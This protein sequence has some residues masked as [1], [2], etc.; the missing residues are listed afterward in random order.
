MKNVK[1]VLLAALLVGAFAWAGE[2]APTTT[3]KP[4]VELL[5]DTPPPA[6]VVTPAPV[7][8]ANPPQT[9]RIEVVQVPAPATPAP[10]A[11]PGPIASPLGA[12][13]VKTAPVTPPG[14]TSLQVKTDGSGTTTATAATAPTWADTIK[15]W[16]LTLFMAV[17]GTLIT[18]I[19]VKFN[20]LIEA[21][22]LTATDKSAV[23]ALNAGVTAAEHELYDDFVERSKDGELSAAD[24]KALRDH[25]L[26]VAKTVAKGP[27]LKALVDMAPARIHDLIE[28]IVL[29][30]QAQQAVADG[31][32]V[33]VPA[34]VI[35][36]P[37]K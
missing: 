14:G 2:T 31:V 30:R 19:G 22:K 5:T 34:P 28:R 32:P 27:A 15:Q 3:P 7:P 1:F 20:G 17:G 6:Q 16:L 25:A 10:A 35:A 24:K 12:S 29:N 33:V 8:V 36:A 18:W 13:D 4:R 21:S 23:E 11:Q 26:T 9:V 37:A